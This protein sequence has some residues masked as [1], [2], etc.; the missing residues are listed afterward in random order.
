MS[1]KVVGAG[2]SGSYL[3]ALAKD[4]YDLTVYDKAPNRRGHI[5][6]WGCLRDELKALLSQVGLNIED[7]VLAEANQLVLNGVTMPV[8]NEIIID[9][10]KML[11]DLLPRKK[12]LQ[13]E[14]NYPSLKGGIIVNATAQPTGSK[15]KSVTMQDKVSLR[16]LEANTVYLEID[17]KHA[18]YAW[19]FPL[20]QSLWHF[21]AGCVGRHP[22][23]L[24][25]QFIKRYKPE[26]LTRFC[27]CSRDI[28]IVDP[29]AAILVEDGVFHIGEAA[30]VVDPLLG[31]GILSSMESAKLLF[32]SLP[33]G[34]TYEHD[35]RK[36]LVDY[37]SEAY[38]ILQLIL[39]HPRLGLLK[40]LNLIASKA[41]A[42]IHAEIS[43]KTKLKLLKQILF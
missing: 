25:C 20:G 28:N 4:T 5:C 29:A 41:E 14:V 26:M 27:F 39:K 18:G 42:T 40:G 3:Y 17:P 23:F 24:L 21:G 38:E 10:P 37:N 16:G 34:T 6:A 8:H 1:L 43:V 7:Y 11:E 9:K 2:V 33:S 13:R 15:T 31:D 12:V 19:A 36:M 35:M 32:N 22:Y 30:G